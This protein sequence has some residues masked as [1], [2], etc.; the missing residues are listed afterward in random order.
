ML[1]WWLQHTF[2][3]VE[4]SIQF[5]NCDCIISILQTAC[6]G[7]LSSHVRFLRSCMSSTRTSES[8]FCF[9]ARALSTTR[10]KATR[11]LSSTTPKRYL[12]QP[13]KSQICH[14]SPDYFCNSCKSLGLQES[15]SH[16]NQREKHVFITQKKSAALIPH[17]KNLRI[18]EKRG[19]RPAPTCLLS[20]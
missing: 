6:R 19:P 1:H 14:F 11:H 8:S 5:H 9:A 7:L 16:I 10:G 17:I 15:L 18:L 13:C 4:T 2:T 3:E 12:K 20:K